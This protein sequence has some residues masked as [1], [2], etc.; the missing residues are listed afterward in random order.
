MWVIG[1]K[2]RLKQVMTNLLSNASKFSKKGAMVDIQLSSNDS[3]VF[4]S[5]KDYGI[6]IPEEAR[7]NIFERFTQ[8]DSSDQRRFG[9]TGLGLN[10]A[11]TIIEEHGGSIEFQSEVGVGTTFRFSLKVRVS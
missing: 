7:A 11:K 10:I 8:A 1:D 2:G 5:V 4:V 9:G 3:R 6:G